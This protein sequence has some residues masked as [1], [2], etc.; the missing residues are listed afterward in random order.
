MPR[1][2]ARGSISRCHA[3]KYASR[4]SMGKPV[5]NTVF[6]LSWEHRAFLNSIIEAGPAFAA[7][8][9]PTAPHLQRALAQQF[10]T[11]SSP[12]RNGSTALRH[13]DF[14]T[15]QPAHLWIKVEGNPF[16]GSIPA[17]ALLLLST[18]GQDPCEVLIG[19]Q[20]H[21][22]HIRHRRPSAFGGG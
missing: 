14:T 21:L 12:A 1:T 10:F 17:A 4:K 2:Q 8:E 13:S 7:P 22:T 15:V 20:A 6:C 9:G 18:P 3:R 16:A 19:K 11:E 5:Q